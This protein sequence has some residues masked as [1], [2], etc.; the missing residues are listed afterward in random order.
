ML[1][2]TSAGQNICHRDS[3][4]SKA[5]SGCMSAA[6]PLHG[7]SQL[8]RAHL[9]TTSRNSTARQGNPKCGMGTERRTQW[10]VRLA[11]VQA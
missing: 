10:L 6:Q 9:I 11:W 5:C 7:H 1:Y 2:S 4:L 3:G 8:C